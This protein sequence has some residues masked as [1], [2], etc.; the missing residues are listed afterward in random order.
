[1][2]FILLFL[3]VKLLALYFIK[4]SLNYLSIREQRDFKVD[5]KERYKFYL[6]LMV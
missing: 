6:N 4:Y 1:M 2:Y 5:L 3:V